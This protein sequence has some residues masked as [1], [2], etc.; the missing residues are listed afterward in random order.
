[1][2]TGYREQLVLRVTKADKKELREQGNKFSLRISDFARVALREGFKQIKDR[3]VIEGSA[4]PS[5]NLKT[6]K[7]RKRD[8]VA[9]EQE[10]KSLLDNMPRPTQRVLLAL[11]D[12]A[13]R[14]TEVL[15]LPWNMI[16]EKAGIIRL[17]AGNVKEKKNR[18]VPIS[19]ELRRVLAEL[20][21]EQKKGANISSR[22]VT[23]NG[24]GR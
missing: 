20:Q 21:M 6:E 15:R 18:T 8:R 23:R 4:A 16:D 22:V 11:Y 9:S 17:P 19:P 10:Y 24:V 13:M 14:A 7:D 1:M 3:G 12:T 2:R 5:V